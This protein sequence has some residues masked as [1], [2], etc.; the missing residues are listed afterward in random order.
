[1]TIRVL[2]STNGDSWYATRIGQLIEVSHVEINRHP[3]QGLP[4]S[5]YWCR[6]G[7]TWN[8]LNYVRFSDAV[9]EV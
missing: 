7:D 8:T 5:V 2:K 9:I 6:T 3:G 4:E 1:M